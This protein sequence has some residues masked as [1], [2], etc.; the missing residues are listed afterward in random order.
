MILYTKNSKN[1]NK[2]INCKLNL[3][4]AIQKSNDT[5]TNWHLKSL[6]SYYLLSTQKILVT[7]CVKHKNNL[8]NTYLRP[9]VR[10][11]CPI[12]LTISWLA[13]S[14]A[15]L[16][17]PLICPFCSSLSAPFRTQPFVCMTAIDVVCS[18]SDKSLFFR[19]FLRGGSTPS[20]PDWSP[21]EARLI[22][23]TRRGQSLFYPRPI[24]IFT[25]MYRSEIITVII[26]G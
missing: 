23:N 22:N 16:T 5:L 4:T 3:L 19:D 18:T 2:I 1:W 6:A 11:C 20:L 25:A 26:L 10:R 14:I 13:R 8:S 9:T 21:D 15:T 24:Q 17:S 12:S 7:L